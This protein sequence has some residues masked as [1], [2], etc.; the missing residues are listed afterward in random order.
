MSLKD[1][2]LGEIRKVA[3][4]QNKLLPPLTDSLHLN[5]SGFDSL[6]FAILAARLEDITC[7]DP[8]ESLEVGRFPQTLGELVALYQEAH[9]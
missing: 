1:V 9:A 8:F 4:E 3:A 2:I 7:R 5:D 6:C